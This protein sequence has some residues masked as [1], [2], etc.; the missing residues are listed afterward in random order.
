IIY[1]IK[2]NKK[3]YIIKYN[4]VNISKKNV[5]NIINNN[6]N[7]TMPGTSTTN[8]YPQIKPCPSTIK[9]INCYNGGTCQILIS[10]NNFNQQLS[11]PFCRCAPNFH[12]HN[13][14]YLFN[15]NI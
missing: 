5:L 7:K 4:L 12:G 9:Q 10:E 1:F 8:F 13:C 2:L 6:I 3:K 15:L 14:Q 11:P